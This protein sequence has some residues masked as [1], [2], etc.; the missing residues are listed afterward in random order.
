MSDK[1]THDG[2]LMRIQ[3]ARKLWGEGFREDAAA[4]IFIATAA[5]SRVRY[6]REMGCSDRRAF[7]AFVAEQVATITNGVAPSPLCFPKT[8]KLPGVNTSQNVAL[9]DIFYGCWR[10]VMIHE[11]KWPVQVYLTPET[12]SSRYNT[13]I[14]LEADGRLGLPEQWI[15]GLA[16]AV[17]KSAEIILPQIMRYPCY[18]IFE[19]DSISSSGNIQLIPGKSKVPTIDIRNQDAVPIFTNENTLK[20]FLNHHKIQHRLVGQFMNRNELIEFVHCG[21]ADQRFIFDPIVGDNPLPSYSLDCVL[22]CIVE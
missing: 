5:I 16:M 11:A 9:E 4:L 2:P 18:A 6:P 20:K 1:Q 13:T 14:K 10:C 7:T 3:A 17:E 15:L 21:S 19:K 22:A 12:P 8:C